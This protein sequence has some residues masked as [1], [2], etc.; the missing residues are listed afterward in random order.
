[1]ASV[2]WPSTIPQSPQ[3]GFTETGGVLLARTPMDKGLPKVRRL[4]QSPKML[5][6]TFLF[7]ASELQTFET[8]V[9]STIKG[10]L[11]FNYKHPRTGAIEEM[12]IVGS[13]DGQLFTV[14]YLAPGYYN[15]DLQM[16]VLP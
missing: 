9:Y 5:N 16:E 7:T 14:K 3:K 1:M 11:R 6:M 15:V 4:G 8:F 13:N 2:S 10:V 12:R